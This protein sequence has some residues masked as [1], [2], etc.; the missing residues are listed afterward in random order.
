VR[1]ALDVTMIVRFSDRK[2][3]VIPNLIHWLPELISVGLVV[4]A[5]AAAILH[6]LKECSQ[7]TT[8]Q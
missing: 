6:V 8:G 4:S 7:K 2:D 1:F 3:E 5:I